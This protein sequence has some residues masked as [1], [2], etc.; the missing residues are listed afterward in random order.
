MFKLNVIAA[1]LAVVS[2]LPARAADSEIG[3]IREEIRRMRESY[4]KRIEALER[5]LQ[6]A[7]SKAVKAETAATSAQSS[8]AKAETAVVAAAARPASESAFNPGISLILSGTVAKLSQDPAGYRITGVVPPNNGVS[9]GIRGFSL[10]ESELA[11]SANIDPY[12]RGTALISIDE[13]NAVSVEEAYVETLGLGHGLSLKGGRF[14][15]A[16]GYQNQV[17]PHAWDFVD[18]SLVQVAFL[19]CNYGDDGVQAKWIA[20]TDL[21]VELG[22]EIGRGKDSP[23]TSRN[24]NG[25]GAGSLFAHVGGDIG[26]G[27]AYRIGASTLRTSPQSAVIN[28][29]DSVS[30]TAVANQFTGSTRIDGIDFIFKYAPNGNSL[31]TNFKLQAEYFRRRQ[32]GVLTFDSTAAAGGPLTDTYNTSQYGW[33]L[34][35][36][37]QFMPRWRVGL[38]HDRMSSGGVNL[39][40]AL[41]PNV[42]TFDYQPT[43]NAVMVDWS[44]SEFS[45]LRLQLAQD[46]SRQ[47][48]TDNQV[49]LQYL[50]S[51]GRHGA[52]AF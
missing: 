1:A 51:L 36:V 18:C 22:A 34:Q 19:G 52:H 23:G 8:A 43:R 48:V 2:S 25:A 24:K 9:P 13:A 40:T 6:D 32:D 49:F 14:F 42:P 44:P 38:R 50:Y 27:G 3:Q 37:Y 20:P 31:N 10:R 4:E 26:A 33:Y 21:L 15:S 35:G 47:G 45:R 7:E 17:H 5:R 28:D 39:G 11:L 12:F 46:K 29:I 41:Q 30:G 16:I